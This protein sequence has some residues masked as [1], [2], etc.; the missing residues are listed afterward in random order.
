MLKYARVL[1]SSGRS[2]GP[3]TD[4]LPLYNN[5]LWGASRTW[6]YICNA[7]VI[8]LGCY[9]GRLPQQTH[10]SCR[11]G[12]PRER[13]DPCA[14]TR[15]PGEANTISNLSATR[16]KSKSLR[17]PL[18]SLQSHHRSLVLVIYVVVS[19]RETTDQGSSGVFFRGWKNSPVMEGE[20]RQRE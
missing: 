17:S 1:I 15:G 14:E 2:Q 12:G 3:I 11:G 9:A 8:P 4:T 6:A 18:R 7:W 20:K 13:A 19:R 10:S 5:G 16:A